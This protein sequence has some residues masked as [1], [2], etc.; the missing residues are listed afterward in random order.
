MGFYEITAT[1]LSIF[2]ILLYLALF[3]TTIQLKRELNQLK[4]STR[5]T[6]EELEIINERLEKLKTLK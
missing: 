3:I 4:Q 6:E 2:S 5:L 1:I